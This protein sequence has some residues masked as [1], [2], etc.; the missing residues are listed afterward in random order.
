MATVGVKGLTISRTELYDKMRHWRKAKWYD[1]WDS[2]VNTL[3][4][5]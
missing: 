5:T 3:G 4:R 1:L 2:A